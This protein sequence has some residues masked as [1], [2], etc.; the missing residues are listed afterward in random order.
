[1]FILQVRWVD[2]YSIRSRIL[3]PD[4]LQKWLA[5]HSLSF[6][7]LSKESFGPTVDHNLNFRRELKSWDA[8]KTQNVFSEMLYLPYCIS[9][10]SLKYAMHIKALFPL[11]FLLGCQFYH[12]LSTE[13]FQWCAAAGAASPRARELGGAP[14]ARR[15]GGHSHP[16]HGGT[17]QSHLGGSSSNTK[18]PLLGWRGVITWFCSDCEPAHSFS[19]ISQV[20]DWGSGARLASPFCR[21]RSFFDR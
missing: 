16:T 13:R 2:T 21:L 10:L 6:L 19:L 1:M 11:R 18:S 20:F 7:Q 14:A 4:P 3:S 12:H 9:E 15:P 17:G 5:N 8:Q